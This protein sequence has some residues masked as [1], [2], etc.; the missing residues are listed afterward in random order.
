MEEWTGHRPP[1]TVSPLLQN[2][3]TQRVRP[4]ASPAPCPRNIPRNSFWEGESRVPLTAGMGKSSPGTSRAGAVPA[5]NVRLAG[6]EVLGV[7]QDTGWGS[8]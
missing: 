8:P 2:C 1:V 5:P 3:S 4:A 7:Q 6:E